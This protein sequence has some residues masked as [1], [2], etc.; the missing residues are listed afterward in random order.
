MK[1]PS[2]L[3][4]A[5]TMKVTLR[6]FKPVKVKVGPV[7]LLCLALDSEKN[8]EV[9]EVAS[10]DDA[11]AEVARL[12][13]NEAKA[14][15]DYIVEAEAKL[16]GV[17][18]SDSSGTVKEADFVLSN[19]P[20]ALKKVGVVRR[21]DVLEGLNSEEIEWYTAPP[22]LFVYEGTI[23]VDGDWGF[24]VLVTDKGEHIITPYDKVTSKAAV[25]TPEKTEQKRTRRTKKKKRKRRKRA[26]KR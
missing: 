19:M 16:N 4:E 21:K 3:L 23:N 13:Y 18:I 17:T 15:K 9:G 25:K 8:V 22:G 10:V 14:H 5:R 20:A 2:P 12:S 11:I 24:L 6:Y 7:E 1:N 26:R